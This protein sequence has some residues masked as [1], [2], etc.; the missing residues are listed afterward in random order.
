MIVDNEGNEVETVFF[1]NLKCREN[2]SAEGCVMHSGDCLGNETSA[3]GDENISIELAGLG[4][5][6]H[7]IYLV[8]TIYSVG[9]YF[10]ED[11]DRQ[12]CCCA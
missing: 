11:Q 8:I 1:G 3:E 9:V 5:H 12:E 2:H 6:V 7:S 4:P 10:H